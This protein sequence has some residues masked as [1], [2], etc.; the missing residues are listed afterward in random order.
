MAFQETI[1]YLYSLQQQGIKFGLTNSF[2]L[3]SCM[4]DPHRRF[5]SIHVAGTNGKGSTAAFLESMLRAAGY[6]VGLYT[7]PHLVSFTER[8]RV[9]G[10]PI[11]EDRV[12]E[13]AERVRECYRRD[14]G[15]PGIPAM[16]PTFFEVTTIMAFTHF[17][18]EAI[19][20]AV[21]ETGMG[22]RLD[23]TNVIT[24]L[25]S[26]ITN[27]DL[28]HTEYLGDTL[29]AIAREKAGIMKEGVPVVTAASQPEVVSV[30]RG[31]AAI[32]R[33]PFYCMPDDF[34]P[35]GAPSGALPH[36]SYQGIATRYANLNI[37]MLGRHQVTNACLAVAAL[38]LAT[39]AGLQVPEQAVRGGLARAIWPGR[40]E[41][42]AVRPSVYLDGAH[43]P[44]SAVVLAEALRDLKRFHR[45]LVLVLGILADKDHRGIIDRL[46]PLA[47]RVIVTQP[48]YARA[49]D[50]A[51]LDR[52]VAPLA[53]DRVC[54][55]TIAEAITEARAQSDPDDL[56]VV[57]G[58]LYTVGEARSLLL[59]AAARDRLGGLKG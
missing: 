51:A 49:M 59:E 57:T 58:S 41:L 48:Q 13:L 54:A 3:M 56:V 1:R 2:L 37:S 53:V 6:R 38:E 20:V 15:T 36:F 39:S 44:A 10:A 11:S 31:E 52:E 30:L 34:G 28:E 46:V 32:R 16:S 19:D 23:S 12:V 45:R 5:R 26:V 40:L 42:V 18:E 21:V 8:I 29:E 25:V 47:D 50:A 4:G 24:P 33:A 17:A 9:N 22:G 27:V 7:S 43:N 55:R 14:E 35:E